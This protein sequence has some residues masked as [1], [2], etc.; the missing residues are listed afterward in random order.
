MFCTQCGQK[1][2]ENANYCIKCGTEIKKEVNLLDNKPKEDSGAI[3]S[4]VLSSEEKVRGNWFLSKIKGHQI[5]TFTFAFLL[6]YRF[7]QLV[8]NY[9]SGIREMYGLNIWFIFILILVFYFLGW[10]LVVWVASKYP[11]EKLK[12]K[13]FQHPIATIIFVFLYITDL[14]YRLS[15]QNVGRDIFTLADAFEIIIYY[16]FISFLCW[17]LVC[18]ISSKIIKQQRFQWLWYKKIVDKIFLVMP[19][20]FKIV[21]GLIVAIFIFFILFV[22]IT[23]VFK[24]SGQD[25]KSIGL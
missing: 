6:V 12:Q 14:P 11:A 5:I 3:I 4:S 25:L 7:T 15:K 9:F 19:V 1:I 2:P 17:L 8:L 13:F 21:L 24:Y 18:W 22:L 23:K 20:I 10:L 16:A